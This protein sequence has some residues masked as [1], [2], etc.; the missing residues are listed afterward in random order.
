MGRTVD[1]LIDEPAHR[2]M[3]AAGRHRAACSSSSRGAR[4]AWRA[5]FQV[6]KLLFCH[7]LAPLTLAAALPFA[8]GWSDTD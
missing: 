4:S 7:T 6:M 8:Q 1:Y 5:A 3:V 2:P